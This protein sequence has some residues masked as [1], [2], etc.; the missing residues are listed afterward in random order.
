MGVCPD[1]MI[2]RLQAQDGTT[3]Q[4]QAERVVDAALKLQ[5]KLN[6]ITGAEVRQE[7][8]CA[9]LPDRVRARSG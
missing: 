4:L 3:R 1:G 9:V 2:F 7:G 6:I 8:K 5:F